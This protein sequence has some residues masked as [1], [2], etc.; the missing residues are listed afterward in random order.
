VAQLASPVAG[1]AA[2]RPW[3]PSSNGGNAG[4]ASAAPDR[5]TLLRAMTDR[6]TGNARALAAAAAAAAAAERLSCAAAHL[7]MHGRG[8]IDV[9]ARNPVT[10][11]V[12]VWLR[13]VA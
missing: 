13:A 2:G 11:T 3:S 8:R 1:D 12:H 7:T 4:G 6:I 5:P 10:E 9:K